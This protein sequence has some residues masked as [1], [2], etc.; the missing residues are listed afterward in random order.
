MQ[1]L[2]K[3]SILVHYTGFDSWLHIS[4]TSGVAG[5][6]V[7]VAQQ[8]SS[9]WLLRQRKHRQQEACTYQ[10]PLVLRILARRKGSPVKLRNQEGILWHKK[11]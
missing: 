7:M 6:E 9:L 5:N 11:F 8:L 1:S 4:N 3:L 10:Q 2:G